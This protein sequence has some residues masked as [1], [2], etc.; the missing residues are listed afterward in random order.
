MSHVQ[1]E[2]AFQAVVDRFIDR[3]V[4][5]PMFV[6]GINHENQLTD[7]AR[8]RARGRGVKGGVP[9]IYVAQHGARS[10][11]IELKW[12]ANK[13]S[14]AQIATHAALRRCG[15]AADVCYSIYDVLAVLRK[16]L[17]DLHGNTMHLATEYQARAEAA[18]R[19]AETRV[20]KT[21]KHRA[22]GT[23]KPSHQQVARV[24][25]AGFAV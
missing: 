6:T 4:T 1:R 18:V 16:E 12:G 21:S 14:D 9:D 22:I 15:I 13:P 11:W 5:P 3:V 10:A 19:T 24:R 7:N 23:S 20:P 8:A 25:R 17:F 2:A